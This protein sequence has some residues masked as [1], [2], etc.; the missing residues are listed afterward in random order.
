MVV[1]Y[2]SNINSRLV[3]FG[4]QFLGP[5][6]VDWYNR[7]T[8]AT[9]GLPTDTIHILGREGWNLVP[10]FNNMESMRGGERRRYLYLH[11]SRA[12]LTHISLSDPDCCNFGFEL[13]YSGTVRN[14]FDSR[15]S[16]P[17]ALLGAPDVGDQFIVLPRDIYYVKKLFGKR[18]GVIEAFSAKSRD[19]YGRYL[20]RSGFTTAG[21]HILSDLGFRGTTQALIS[22]I[23]GFQIKGFYALLD[24][25]SVPA[26]P[27]LALG[28]VAGLFSDSKSFGD[29]F[30][31]LDRSLLLEAWLTAP[32]GQVSGIQDVEHGDPFLYRAGGT[33]QQNFSIIAECFQGAQK[34]ALDNVDLLGSREPL[35][36]D[37]VQFFES[38][39]DAIL[40]DVELF[41]PILA[42]DDSFYGIELNN[43][44]L[45][46]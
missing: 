36:E 4:Y 15:L 21:F 38:Y 28:S 45:Q 11:A 23:Y 16:V 18:R 20:A 3:R 44:E 26:A 9:E 33:S 13:N 10:M 12:L 39:Q 6:L 37:I 7:L 14:F 8:V 41:R 24:P 25:V 40:S 31:P 22:A 34:F 19:A 29:G 1:L 35:I 46:L 30:A 42:I 2:S 5:F 27:P 17:F 43:A 32:F